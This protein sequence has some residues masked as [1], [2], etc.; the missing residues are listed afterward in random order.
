MWAGKLDAR[1]REILGAATAA[2]LATLVGVWSLR[3][4]EWRPGVP[5]A[6]VGDAP[7]VLTQLDDILRHGWFWSNSAVGFPLGQNASFYPELDVV[8]ILGV[9]LLGLFSGD[10]ATVGTVYFVLVYPLVAVTTYLL[11]RSERLTRTS[12][13]VVAVLFAASA[14]HAQR[15]QHFWL[16]AYWTVPVALWVVFLT[17]RGLTPLDPDGRRTRWRVALWILA[18]GLVGLSGA[19]YAG[20]TLILIAAVLVLRAGKGRPTGWWRGGLASIAG[21]GV[22]ASLPLLAARVGMAG[23]AL[24][25]PRPATRNPLESEAYAGRIIDLVLPWEGH[26]VTPLAELTTIYQQAGRPVVETVALGV[27]GVVGAGAL[28][29]IGL[30][31]L[32]LSRPAPPRLLLWA[33]LLGIT[34]LF[35]TTGGLG[36]I[37]ALLVTP[38]LRTWS[39]LALFIL[40]LGL[41][42]VG[43][44]LS[45]PRRKAM[46][47]TLAALVL[48]VGVLDQTNPAT[49]PDYSAIGSRLDGIRGYTSALSD[50]A[51]GGCGVLQLPVMKFPEGYL[52]Q[53]Y[54]I[55]AQLLQHLTTDRLSWS[56]GGMSGTRAGDW[57]QG[58][59]LD[60]PQK[61][62]RELRSAGFCAVEVDTAGV[63]LDNPTVAA[64]TSGLG[65]PV[66]GSADGRL[67]SWSLGA[68]AA[69]DPTDAERLLHPVIVGTSSGENQVDGATV[70]QE[71]GPRSSFFTENMSGDAVGPITVSMD[72]V[73]VGAPER[74]VVVRNG[75]DVVAQ[76]T[77]R[78]DGPTRITFT[79]DAPAGYHTLPLTISGDPLRDRS[80]HSVSARFEN[81][82]VAS[83]ADQHVVSTFDQARSGVVFP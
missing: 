28:L 23:T 71:T 63:D 68:V 31:A 11:C 2:V 64:L 80:G 61:L 32:A 14:Y 47:V 5:L 13:V 38:Q 54:D 36:S 69:G 42:A 48:V 6:V 65:R 44:W 41:L 73:A 70:F 59:A 21:I 57:S 76:A 46:A 62:L 20:F 34:G 79:V 39:R 27:V 29:F 72:M 18:L 66:A 74:E 26:R 45:R 4:W 52:P 77:I 60:D 8:H 17:A 22:V 19:Y 43:H 7:L 24:T 25:G 10:A 16:A 50:A 78:D 51:G 67:V 75:Q 40:L 49:A 3:L 81:L 83:S 33:A 15:F 35:F 30:R 56:H 1:R 12:S 58:M 55:N 37:F 9:K 82:T 53:G